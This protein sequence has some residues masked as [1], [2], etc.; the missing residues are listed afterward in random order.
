MEAP[1]GKFITSNVAAHL[2]CGARDRGAVAAGRLFGCVHGQTMCWSHSFSRQGCSVFCGLVWVMLAKW[3]GSSAVAGTIQIA[4]WV[5]GYGW[6]CRGK[7][8]SGYTD[9]SEISLRLKWGRVQSGMLGQCTLILN[10][11]YKSYE[12]Q[13]GVDFRPSMRKYSN[14]NQNLKFANV[15]ISQ[16][17]QQ[18]QQSVIPVQG[19]QRF[20]HIVRPKASSETSAK[21][22]GNHSAWNEKGFFYHVSNNPY[23]ALQLTIRRLRSP[24]TMTCAHVVKLFCLIFKVKRWIVIRFFLESSVSS[25]TLISDYFLN[26][27]ALCVLLPN[28]HMSATND[29][30]PKVFQWFFWGQGNRGLVQD[31]ALASVLWVF[32]IRWTI[33]LFV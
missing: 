23:P 8:C 3:H 13:R 19:A 30:P 2:H 11:S 10:C 27:F 25:H 28:V 12:K 17:I 18:Q 4:R 15:N 14:R 22:S 9:R 33:K 26:F 7:C 21:G 6:A 29:F 1:E 32:I 16:R 31:V 20:L 24:C 5:T